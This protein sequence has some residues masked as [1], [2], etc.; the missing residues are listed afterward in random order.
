MKTSRGLAAVLTAAGVLAAACGGGSAATGDPGSAKGG[1]D[2]APGVAAARGWV[3]ENAQNPTLIGIDAPLS[4]KPT[5]GRHIVKLVTP[6]PVD[7][8]VS[9][10]AKAAAEVLGWRYTAINVAPDA[11][12]IQKAFQSAFALKPQPDVINVAGYPAVTYAAQLA[13]AKRR[14]IA[15][16]SQTTTDKPGTGDGIEAVLGGPIQLRELGKHVA[17]YVTAN[18]NGSA[19]VALFNVSAYPILGEFANGFKDTLA[20]WCPG[21]SVVEVDQ[22]ATDVGTKT[23]QSVVSTFQRDPRLEWAIF[24]F[25]DMT[26]GVPAALRAAGL[27]DRVKIGGVGATEANIQAV[28]DGKET[29]WTGLSAP[30]MGWRFVDAAARILGGDDLAPANEAILPTQLITRDTVGGIV[31]TDRGYYVGLEDYPEQF[32]KLWQ[33]G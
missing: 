31:T 19:R 13:E 16:V 17:A 30:V 14:G 9:D 8:V 20:Q 12:G 23:P 2:S 33:V 3:A 5:P 4:G 18:S 11:E 7:Q 21:C 15:V 32:K 29:V 22:Q 24:S 26:I 27:A 10:G 1:A 6:Q 28:R 25:G